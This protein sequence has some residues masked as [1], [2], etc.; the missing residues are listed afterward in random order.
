MEGQERSEKEAHYEG[1]MP[2]AERW[3]KLTRIFGMLAQSTH[4]FRLSGEIAKT[5]QQLRDSQVKNLLSLFDEHANLQIGC[6]PQ[7]NLWQLFRKPVKIYLADQCQAEI[8]T[9]HRLSPA[10][11]SF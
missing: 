11:C 6:Y 2:I 1:E 3:K 4:V 5:Y 7:T 8:T 10:C 9:P